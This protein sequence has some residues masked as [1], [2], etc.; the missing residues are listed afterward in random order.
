MRA[1][2][3]V[4]RVFVTAMIMMLGV[5]TAMPLATAAQPGDNGGPGNSGAAHQCQDGGWQQ[6]APAEDPTAGFANQDACVSYGAE[7]GTLV[8]LA[9]YP[10]IITDQTTGHTPTGCLLNFY[11]EGFVNGTEYTATIERAE[12]GS[13]VMSET[14]SMFGP[15][16][17]LGQE[18][19]PGE[20]YGAAYDANGV[21]V[22]LS[23]TVTCGS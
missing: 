2:R 4:L 6:L 7:G 3:R 12:D 21:L 11:Y 8:D 19:E 23:V 14:S 15:T 18:E 1:T 10:I 17:G 9:R 16:F 5:L 20:Y 22:G 13:I